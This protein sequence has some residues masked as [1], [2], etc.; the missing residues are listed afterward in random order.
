MV[1]FRAGYTPD[2]YPTELEWK[3]REVLER[4]SAIKCPHTAFHLAGTKRI[5][6]ELCVPQVLEKYLG[7]DAQS[8]SRYF[9]DQWNFEKAEDLEGLAAKVKA[10]PKGFVLKPQREGGGNNIYGQDIS[11]MLLSKRYLSEYVLMQRL[12]PPMY[13]SLIIKGDGSSF[14]GDCISEFGIYSVLVSDNTRIHQNQTAG[15]LVRT[16]PVNIDEGGVSSGYSALDSP[17]FI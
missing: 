17:L 1:Y 10:D 5:Q 13:K 14:E 11:E 8:V 4:S 15:H 12:H 7:S 9:A 16:K 3:G 6:Q 2:D